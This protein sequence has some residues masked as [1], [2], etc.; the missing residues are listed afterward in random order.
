[1]SALEVTFG[2]C[3]GRM[4]SSSLAERLMHLTFCAVPPS[5]LGFCVKVMM[6]SLFH[7]LRF[8]VPP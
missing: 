3:C 7:V 5:F 4:R 6:R 2:S 8:L 1:M